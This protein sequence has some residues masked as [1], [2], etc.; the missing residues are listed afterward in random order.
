MPLRCGSLTGVAF[1]YKFRQEL[2]LRLRRDT[3]AEWVD[4]VNDNLD[5]FL[6]DHAAN[7]R[8]VS[9]SAMT[10][11]VHHP[12]R[13]E[14]VDALVEASFEEF[15]HF[16][17]IYKLLVERGVSLGQ[18]TPDPYMGKLRKAIKS[19]NHERFLLDRLLLFGIV[20]ARGCERFAML[21]KGL[22]D[23]ALRRIYADLTQ[24]EARHHAMYLQL[25]KTYFE[26]TIVSS[27]ADE[28]L[29]FEASVVAELP[30]LP[31]LH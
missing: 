17:L 1:C 2:M 13:L 30:L 21:A 31:R 28:L 24:S 6:Q 5:A 3:P 25:A 8:K 20:E 7:E 16:R 9:A 29:E 12:D 10:L 15:Q 4:V 18:D 22:A 19:P 11:A 23:P 26:E 27:R 14:L